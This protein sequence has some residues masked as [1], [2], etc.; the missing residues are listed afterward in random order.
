[1]SANPFL[2]EAEQAF[3]RGMAS[4]P[5]WFAILRKIADSCPPPRYRPGVDDQAQIHAWIYR[6]GAF[7]QLEGVLSLLAGR[8]VTLEH[9]GVDLTSEETHGNI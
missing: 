6:S 8:S 2:T 1:M 9:Q 5:R 4:D 3:L 7:T